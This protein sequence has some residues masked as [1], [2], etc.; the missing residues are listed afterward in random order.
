[1]NTGSLASGFS[2]PGQLLVVLFGL[3]PAGAMAMVSLFMLPSLEILQGDSGGAVSIPERLGHYATFSSP[4]AGFCAM[5]FLYLA[6]AADR[7]RHRT[8]A[9]FGL[10]AGLLAA[11][12]GIVVL[13]GDLW[14]FFG[15]WLRGTRLPFDFVEKRLLGSVIWTVVLGGMI[16][17]GLE[18]GRQTLSPSSR[19]ER[20]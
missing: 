5:L 18:L 8:A 11:V 13:A 12:A 20:P 6:P 17:V 14:F 9:T 1:M 3:V 19:E 7:R 2:L 15:H 16:A 10:A 4:I